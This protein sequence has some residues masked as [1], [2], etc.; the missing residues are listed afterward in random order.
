M[1]IFSDISVTNL[2]AGNYVSVTAAVS[3]ALVLLA[4][5][6]GMWIGFVALTLELRKHAHYLRNLLGILL[7]WGLILSQAH[8]MLTGILF[9]FVSVLGILVAC[10]ADHRSVEQAQ[11]PKFQ[12]VRRPGDINHFDFRV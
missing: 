7:V 12:E 4:F 8:D 6:G 10:I 3:S 11:G 9:F 5:S 2:L 1:S